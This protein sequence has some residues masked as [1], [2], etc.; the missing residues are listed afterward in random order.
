MFLNLYV[1]KL[2]RA[3]YRFQFIRLETS[4]NRERA[5]LAYQSIVQKQ[6]A[7][8]KQL[9][10]VGTESVTV[11][12][13]TFDAYKVEVVAADNEADKTTL[14]IDKATHKVVKIVAVLPSLGGALLT[15]ELQ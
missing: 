8:L 1:G 15:S 12:G 3:S 4:Q 7:Q 9:K 5:V 11:P 2:R 10:V 13:G 14:W 6:K